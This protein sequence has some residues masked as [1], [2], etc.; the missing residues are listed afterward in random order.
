[1]K[2]VQVAWGLLFD[3]ARL[4]IG[5]VLSLLLAALLAYVHAAVPAA[6]VL[7]LGLIAALTISIRHEQR[8]VLARRQGG[9]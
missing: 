6:I 1:M 2:A 3:D 9:R 7:W 5:V 4:G 8:S